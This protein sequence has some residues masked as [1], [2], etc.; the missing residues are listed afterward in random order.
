MLSIVFFAGLSS[1][2]VFVLESLEARRQAESSRTQVR[3]PTCHCRCECTCKDCKTKCECKCVENCEC[4]RVATCVCFENPVFIVLTGDGNP[5]DGSLDSNQDAVIQNLVPISWCEQFDA[6]RVV[7]LGGTGRE[8]QDSVDVACSLNSL[9]RR[10]LVTLEEYLQQTAIRTLR[11]YRMKYH[12]K[13]LLAATQSAKDA[14]ASGKYCTCGLTYV[15]QAGSP[16]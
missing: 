9:Q 16:G 8:S 10:H 5:E 14:L 3:S 12:L 11:H 4:R 1:A 13:E 6:E 15:D 7:R 2:Y